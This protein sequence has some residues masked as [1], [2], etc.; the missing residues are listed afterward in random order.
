MAHTAR[1]LKGEKTIR[2]HYA[3]CNTYNA[4]FDGDEMNLHFP[5]NEIARAEAYN[6]A[7][8]N[9]QYLVPTDGNPLRGLIQDHVVTGVLMTARDCFFTREE[10][11]QVIFGCLPESDRK[12][13]I[14]LPPALIKPKPLWTGKQV[15]S[16]VLK[17]LTLGKPALNLESKS[18]TPARMWEPFPEESKVIFMDGDL[19]CGVL[20]KSQF[21]ASAFGLV[22]VSI[23]IV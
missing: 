22:H 4:D 13:I 2:M 18:R 21:G 23:I 19:L 6:I 12:M 7:N 17:N 14:T 1:V 8:T 11:H 20:D 9:N 15:V 10:Y 5:Q 3:N 16:T